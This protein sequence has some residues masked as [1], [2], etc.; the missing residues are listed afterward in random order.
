MKDFKIQFNSEITYC[1]A[2]YAL[3]DNGKKE[4]LCGIDLFKISDNCYLIISNLGI[5][6]YTFKQFVKRF[7]QYRPNDIPENCNT[8]IFQDDTNEENVDIDY[9][10]NYHSLVS[11]LSN[12]EKIENNL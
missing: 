10:T 8:F 7:I 4:F 5:N 2:L 11:D 9:I 1:M 3:C 12:E 6:A